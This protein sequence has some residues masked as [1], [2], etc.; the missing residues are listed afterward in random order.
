MI[1]GILSVA[2]LVSCDILELSKRTL[3]LVLGWRR[4]TAL[5]GVSAVRSVHVLPNFWAILRDSWS[6]GILSRKTE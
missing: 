1:C 4:T 6:R 3:C 5:Q 2:L